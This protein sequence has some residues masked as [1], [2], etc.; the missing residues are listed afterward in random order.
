MS[1]DF[2]D[3]SSA[4]S[5]AS[6]SEQA[7]CAESMQA[8]APQQLAPTP[9]IGGES[10]YRCVAQGKKLERKDAGRFHMVR[11]AALSR[12]P[13]EALCRLGENKKT[14]RRLESKF[15][16][17]LRP[18]GEIAELMFDRFWSSHLRC[19][20][21]ARSEALVL[22]PKSVPSSPSNPTP[23]LRE[24]E[25]PTLVLADGSDGD[26]ITD[27]IP[28]DLF[29]RLVLVQRYDRH[30]S[31]E[32]YRA[33]AVLL[34]LRKEGEAGLE[35]CVRNLLGFDILPKERAKDA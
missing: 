33:L 31:R 1:E 9:E 12:H 22:G 7:H 16:A 20:L 17:A 5:K 6:S 4:S 25:K 10:P 30:F 19:L 34:I 3:H 35:R 21:A 8:N 26:T 13:L 14:L 24:A 15:R 23:V 27:Q 11:H 28:V 29:R 2:S 32:M 18:R